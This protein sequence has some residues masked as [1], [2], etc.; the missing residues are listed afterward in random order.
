MRKP[1]VHT[2]Q[3]SGTRG[4]RPIRVRPY[5]RLAKSAMQPSAA[6]VYPSGFADVAPIGEI[7]TSSP[8]P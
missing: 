4:S 7:V 5:F 8:S 6:G 3:I 1:W 2:A